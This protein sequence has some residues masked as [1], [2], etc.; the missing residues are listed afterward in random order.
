MKASFFT[1][2]I[3]YW[4]VR[5]L[6]AAACRLPP[7]VSVA[8][9]RGLGRLAYHALP[10]RRRAALSN[11]QMAYEGAY[12]RRELQG[13]A[14]EVFEHFGMTLMEVAMMPRMDRAYMD[15]WLTISPESRQRVE[16]AL[17]QGHGAIFLTAH[18]G[19]WEIGSLAAALRG[20]PLLV[21]AREQGWPRLN[22]LLNRYRESR[23]CRVITKGFPIR[24]MI[25]GLN[26]GRLVGILSD[27]DGGR[28]GVLAPFLGKLAS[29]APGVINLSLSTQAP[30]LPAFAVRRR[31]PAF[32]FY[33]EEPLVIPEE[34]SLEERIRHGVE[35]YVKLLETYVRRYP[36][37]W[38]WM[39]RRWKTSPQRR[40][41]LVSDGK[42][43]HRNQLMAFS[44]RTEQALKEKFRQDQRLSGISEPLLKVKTVE[45]Q[46]RSPLGR[47]AVS[48][49]AALLPKGWPADFILRFA[50]KTE[51]YRA[52]ASSY[53]DLTASCGSAAAGV[54]LLW[55]AS[56]GARAIHIQ[57]SDFPCWRRFDL[58]VIPR[59]DRPRP[60]SS[61]R[62]IVIDGALTDGAPRGAQ[63]IKRW[64]ELLATSEAQAIGLLIGGPGP[65]VR[66]DLA[67]LQGMIRGLLSSAERLNVPLLVT[68]SRRTGPAAEEWLSRN[69]GSHP[70]CRLLTLVGRGESGPLNSTG[71]AVACIFAL[72]RA[73]V[74]TGDSISMVSEAVASQHPV[75]SFL[76]RCA[77]WFGSG[78]K[79]HRFLE[80]LAQAGKVT[81]AE[82]QAVGEAV[83][84]ALEKNAP[85]AAPSSDPVV[86]RL[87]Q[88][89]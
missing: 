15:R 76:P 32:S 41:L 37:Q 63:E 21:L 82:P 81:L 84:R 60:A 68:T 64:E 1:E 74:V 6:S 51:A 38:L 70:R 17:A 43:G 40:L 79:H 54:N 2:S 42:A 78:S 86:E 47:A 67:D 33:V 11:L 49:A 18:F 52:L 48:L 50:L 89:L 87:A 16:Q 7:Q 24:E 46:F 61:P 35:A 73:L 10:R 56:T 31:G 8:A 20:Y 75:V 77:G 58:A 83:A 62:L 28:H 23:G 3:L 80:G 69:L 88:W 13:L 5:G 19:N 12:G 71:E 59:H 22:G 34:G 26:A 55:A 27:Q 9:G 39:H 36:A 14:R 72:S 30:I 25:H 85:A 45:I 4:L 65:G 57:R 53:A 29:T 44:R 66:L